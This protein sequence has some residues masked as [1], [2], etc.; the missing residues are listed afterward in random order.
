MYINCS[1]CLFFNV[2]CK[3][4]ESKNIKN[5]SVFRVYMN[6]CGEE[7]DLK[8]NLTT[9]KPVGKLTSVEVETRMHVGMPMIILF[10]PY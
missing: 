7:S 10:C 6:Q 4:D 3:K 9:V 5:N 8:S 1:I 2:S